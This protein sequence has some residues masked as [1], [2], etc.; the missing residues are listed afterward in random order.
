[1]SKDN[2]T[3][4]AD[5]LKKFVSGQKAVMQAAETLAVMSIQQ[6]A[7]HGSLSY[8]QQFC[9]SMNRN[10]TRI[11]AFLAWMTAFSPLEFEG[12][13]KNG[14]RLSKD[15]SVDA[16]E[17][18]VEAALKTPFW[19]FAP[20]RDDEVQFTQADFIKAVKRVIAKYRKDNHTAT[21]ELATLAVNRAEIA[22][23]HIETDLAA[24]DRSTAI[25]VIPTDPAS[26]EAAESQA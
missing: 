20:Q 15:K 8:A 3:M 9:D 1:M 4:F 21:S 11:T 23:K 22:M 25:T 2:D 7:D 18:D 17:F 24:K 19:D 16:I 13:I 26:A 6:F 5:V 12:N 10:Y 14:Y